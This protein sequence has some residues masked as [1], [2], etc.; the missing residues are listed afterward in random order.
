MFHSKTWMSFLALSTE[1]DNQSFEMGKARYT[2]LNDKH[3]K[4]K[5]IRGESVYIGYCWLVKI[6]TKL[7]FPMLLNLESG[8]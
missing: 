6:Y 3:L 8:Y 5:F 7:L 4:Y 1:L 2:H